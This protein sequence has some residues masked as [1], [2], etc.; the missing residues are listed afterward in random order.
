MATATA[1][2]ALPNL[3]AIRARKGISLQE[4]AR[5]TKISTRYLEAI[6]KS[7]FSQLPGGVFTTSYI[8]QYARAIEY[9]EWDLLAYF[10]ASRHQDEEQPPVRRERR[11]LGIFRLPQPIVRLFAPEKRA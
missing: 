6:E 1:I 3:T 7:D 5:T 8:R 9:D 10:D 11:L 2:S 4:I